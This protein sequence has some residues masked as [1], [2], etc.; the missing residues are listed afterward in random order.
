MAQS[1]SF[2]RIVSGGTGGTYYPIAGLIANAIS[3]PPGSR[4]CDEGGSCGVPG[5][6]AI[7]QSSNGGAANVT[8]VGSGQAEGGF[9]PAD[10]LEWSNKATGPYEGQAP[11]DTIRVVSNLFAEHLHLVTLPGSDISSYSD[12]ADKRVGI[13]SAGSGTQIAVLEIL[14]QL[15]L[16]RDDF[17]AEELNITQSVERL[18]DGAL[19]AFFYIAGV[20]AGGIAQLAA[21][22]GLKLVGMSAE[23]QAS[24]L[25]VV[26]FYQASEIPAGAYDGVEEPIATLAVGTQFVVNADLDDDLVYGICQALWSEPA[27]KLLDNGHAKGREIVLENALNGVT[28]PLHPGA[29]KFYREMGML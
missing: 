6:V 13:G 1:P 8:A 2:F 9:A 29:E 7:A 28:L 11:V 27:R 19:D 22:A 16:A 20:P 14:G 15:G 4:G 18:Q 25:E 24:A 3:N 23:E 21:T 10:L 12:L 26:P 5:L 17:S